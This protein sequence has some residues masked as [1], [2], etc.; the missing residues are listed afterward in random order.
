MAKIQIVFRKEELSK[1][2]WEKVKDLTPGSSFQVTG[3]V[4]KRNE[5]KENDFYR[6]RR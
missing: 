5:K 3:I 6:E 1:E 2:D 4:Q